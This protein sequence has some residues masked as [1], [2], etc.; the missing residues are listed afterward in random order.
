MFTLGFSPCPNDCFMFDAMVFGKIDT[1]GLEFDVI[2]DDV[3]S[4]NTM[5]LDNQL[6]ISKIS[7]HTFLYLSEKYKILNSGSAL[8]NGCG[9]ILISRDDNMRTIIDNL[10]TKDNNIRIAIPGRYTTANLLLN[11]AFPE[12][13]NFF[14]MKFFDIEDAVLK[15]DVDAGVIIHENRFTYQDKGLYKVLDLGEFWE[16]LAI[17]PIPLGGIAIK[18]DI[19]DEIKLKVNRV[20]RRSIE[21]AFNN[22]QASRA[23]VKRNAQEMS[24]EVIFK[25]IDLYVNNFSIDLGNEGKR[26]VYLL[27]QHANRIGLITKKAEDIF[28]IP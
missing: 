5:A 26:A 13:V 24:E 7:Y 17:A 3:E 27:M 23:F 2:M 11:I 6:D 15:G 19:P 8:G 1:E 18:K 12:F 14:E 4:L 28:V 22:P 9:P 21:Y 20:L 10:K 16:T 25:H